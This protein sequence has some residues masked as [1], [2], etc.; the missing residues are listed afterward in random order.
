MDAFKLNF[1]VS[2]FLNIALSACV[3]ER[4]PFCF[5]QRYRILLVLAAIMSVRLSSRV[6][7]TGRVWFR[8]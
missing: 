4:N 8:K 7:V 3:Q 2:I 6:M 1:C 5:A